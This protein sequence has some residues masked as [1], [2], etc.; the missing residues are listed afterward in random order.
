MQTIEVQLDIYQVSILPIVDFNGDGNVDSQDLSILKENWGTDDSLYD[1]GPMPWGDGIVDMHDLNILAEYV[2]VS[3]PALVH[4]PS[5]PATDVPRNVTLSWQPGKF[6]DTH[7]VYLG[8][9]FEDVIAADRDHPQDVL[10]SQGQ[11]ASTFDLE[12]LIDFGK[13]YYWRI[14]EVNARPDSTIYNGFVWSFTV[15]PRSIP[16]ETAITVTASGFNPGMEPSKT[17]DGSG[18]DELDKHS[19]NPTDMWLTESAGSWIQYEFDKVYKLHEVLIW[20][21]NQLIE[22]LVGFG[23]KDAIIETSIDG[24]TWVQV[25]DVLPFS[26]ASGSPDYVANTT[27]DLSDIMAKYVKIIPQS[28]YGLTGRSGLSE[29]RFYFIPTA[30]RKPNPADGATTENLDV[31]LTWHA[32]REAVSHEIYLSTDIEAVADG[33]AIVDIVT[34]ARYVPD[35]LVNGATYYWK[36]VEVNNDETPATYTSDIWSFTTLE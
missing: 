11:Y 4:A 16:V 2:D 1:I 31:T 33:T 22:S 13:T 19:K 17:I 36:I 18:L 26:Q 35:S 21:S 25:A 14:D 28:A 32:G 20:N 34:E 23:I 29:V 27:V 30:A 7:D 15:E 12:G 6:A 8:T 5:S 24:T 10:V 3:G 9:I